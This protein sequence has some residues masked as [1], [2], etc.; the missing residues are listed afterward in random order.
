M[1][2]ELRGLLPKLLHFRRQSLAKPGR[3]RLPVLPDRLMKRFRC[4]FQMMLPGLLP[5]PSGLPGP[6]MLPGRLMLPGLLKQFHHCFPGRLPAWF[7][8]RV[9]QEK[10]FL[11]LR[12]SG[13]L[14]DLSA[15]AH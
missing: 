1:G 3:L 5:E 12:P 8:P 7:C 10:Y 6:S 9:F 2:Q 11:L 15:Q 13:L 14:P 4:R